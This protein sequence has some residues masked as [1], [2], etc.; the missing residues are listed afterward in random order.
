MIANDSNYAAFEFHHIGNEKE[1]EVGRCLNRKWTIVQNELQKCILLCSCCHRILHSD[2]DNDDIVIY[3]KTPAKKNSKQQHKCASCNSNIS[4]S[5]KSGLCRQCWTKTQRRCNRPSKHKLRKMI[6]ELGLT[7][8]AKQY[9]V[10]IN[11]IKK[12]L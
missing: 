6:E 5:S 7:Q 11:A 8:V 10:T 12:W 4:S 1:F 2:Y 9:G 3:A